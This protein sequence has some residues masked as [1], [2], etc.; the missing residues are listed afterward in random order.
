MKS[1]RRARIHAHRRA[2]QS[3]LH[4]QQQEP[5]S[6]VLAQ[7][8]DS[9][10]D[11]SF[12]NDSLLNSSLFN[13]SPIN[14]ASSNSAKPKKAS[15]WIMLALAAMALGLK[16][17][18]NSMANTVGSD[19]CPEL[20]NH[21]MKQLHSSNVLNLCQVAD[22]KPVLLVNTASHC[23]FTGQFED[24]EK[25]HAEF[26]GQGL[27]VIGVSSNSFDQ[28]AASEDKIADV[29]FKNFGVTFT[30]LAPVPVKGP[31]A[32]PLFKAVGE[33]SGYPRWNFYKYLISREG[34]IVESWSSFGV[35]DE[36]D[37]KMV[38]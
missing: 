21:D 34:K 20:L 11:Y 28:E 18:S 24:L 26:S 6:R 27:V 31:N 16:L 17:S 2:Q 5:E 33:A 9:M 7:P 22:G 25:L 30:M 15:R 35:P 4:R 32:H 29:C 19:E 3:A 1:A 37:L 8:M 13:S 12:F 36:K 10:P 14:N 38:F 23:G